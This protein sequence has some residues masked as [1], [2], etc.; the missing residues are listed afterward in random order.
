[1]T[2]I[3][4]KDGT[5]IYYKDWARTAVVFS[6]GWPLSPTAGSRRCCMWRPMASARLRTTVGP[7]TLQSGHVQAMTWNTYADDLAA[8]V[9]ALESEDAVLVGFSTAWRSGA[10]IVRHGPAVSAKAGLIAAVPPLMLKTAATRR[11]PDDVFDGILRIHRQS[12]RALPR[13]RKRAVLRIQPAGAKS[14]RAD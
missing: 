2:T 7:R 5:H 9:E 8:L 14:R 3:I 6:H 13:C 12:I 4:V 1:M 10:Y 11:P